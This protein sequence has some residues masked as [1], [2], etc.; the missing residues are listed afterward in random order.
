MAA[1]H[2]GD[3]FDALHDDVRRLGALLG[4][5][6]EEAGGTDLYEDVERLRRAVRDVRRGDPGPDPQQLVDE[7][8][9]DQAER[10][11][12][13]FTVLFHLV[14]LAEERHRV[15]VLRSRDRNDRDPSRDSLA[16]AI[17]ALG[18]DGAAAVMRRLEVHPVFTAHPTEARRRAVVT[19]LRRISDELERGDDP[20]I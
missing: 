5:V 12:R 18:V 10:V 15:R 17:T 14:N 1:E 4:Q 7:L 16:G 13:A 19:A 20:R 6:V 3:G 9:L 11:A 8:D 2:P